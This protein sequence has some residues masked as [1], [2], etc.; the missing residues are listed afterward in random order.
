[1]NSGYIVLI[2]I[3]TFVIILLIIFLT[4]ALLNNQ[5]G[6]CDAVGQFGV[7]NNI[8]APILNTCSPN[9]SPCVFD[10]P[11]LLTAFTQCQSLNCEAFVYDQNRATVSFVNIESDIFRSDG[12]SL[13]VRQDGQ[14]LS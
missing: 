13:F 4:L 1:M 11:D 5:T 3:L 2:F 6:V 12:V 8:S 9:N 10:A 7:Q 14:L